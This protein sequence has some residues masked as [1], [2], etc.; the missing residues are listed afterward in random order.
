[1]FKRVAAVCAL[2]LVFTDVAVAQPQ[3]LAS[4][5]PLQLIAA[6]L[7]DGVA[8]P[9][10]LIPANVSPHHFTLRPSDVRKMTDA[11]LV[12]WVGPQMETYLTD[13]LG[14]IDGQTVVVEVA[15]LDGIILHA[16]GGGSEPQSAARYD[17]HLWLNTHNA[18]LVAEQITQHLMTLD[19][20]NR[21]RYQANLSR[22]V[23][24]I[25]TLDK[26]TSADVQRLKDGR[27]AVYH[28]G[29]QYFERQ[30]GLEHQFV[31]VPDHEIQP[32]IRHILDIRSRLEELRPT[33]LLE[34]VNSNDS[35]TETVFG[36]YPVNRVRVDVLGDAISP[37]PGSYA[38]L[39]G[40]LAQAIN[41]C[42]GR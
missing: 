42:L 31:L 34:D 22:F 11:G 12:L 41:T 16:P 35:T 37:G 5:K 17:P 7:M 3:V 30:F 10:L 6:D 36:D 1:M 33:C 39:I 38:Q 24:S 19:P 13:F 2:I 27:Y 32:G 29:L 40:N 25:D 20:A 18:R 15:A 14:Q 9:E 23:A 8:K 21:S 4:I 26:T 28:D